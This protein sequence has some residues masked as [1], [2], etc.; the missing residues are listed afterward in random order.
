[1]NTMAKPIDP[2]R[3]IRVRI[4][5]VRRKIAHH[6]RYLGQDMLPYWQR[7]RPKRLAKFQRELER[8]EAEA[9]KP[10]PAAPA[11]KAKE[12]PGRANL[13]IAE[14]A[15]GAWVATRSF[16]CGDRMIR[17]GAVISAADLAGMRNARQLIDSKFVIWV[18]AGQTRPSLK[19]K[20][21]T[22]AP[23]I[24]QPIESFTT[25]VR[26][27]MRRLFAAGLGVDAVHDRLVQMPIYTKA[28]REFAEANQKRTGRYLT[29]RF[30]EHLRQL[31]PTQENAA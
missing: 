8:L 2:A 21:V 23:K 30:I 12:M 22:P 26:R 16:R 1:M 25:Q 5:V 20:A 13:L 3:E 15:G 10:A 4:G 11:A 6:E 9:A 14:P 7:E 17:H 19:P 28:L 24:E 29:D 27:E 31:P 18:P